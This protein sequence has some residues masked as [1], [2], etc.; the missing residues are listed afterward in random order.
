MAAPKKKK[1]IAFNIQ[2][3]METGTNILVGSADIAMQYYPPKYVK[4]NVGLII[5]LARKFGKPIIDNSD[6]NCTVMYMILSENSAIQQLNDVCIAIFDEIT[7]TLFKQKKNVIIHCNEGRTRSP[8]IAY[9]YMTLVLEWT[10]SLSSGYLSGA[11]FMSCIRSS[12]AKRFL[13]TLN[14]TYSINSD[15]YSKN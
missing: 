12:K 7:K 3:P 15:K 4:K 6:K 10:A 9:L 2:I 5:N 14:Q 1:E 11:K 8:T 13:T